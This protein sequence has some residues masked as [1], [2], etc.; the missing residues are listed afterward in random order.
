LAIAVTLAGSLFGLIIGLI[1][2]HRETRSIAEAMKREHPEDPR[3][4]LPFISLF[5]I[6]LCDA[7]GTLVGIVASVFVLNRVTKDKEREG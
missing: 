5:W 7:I 3:D 1:L 6:V 4:M 2:S